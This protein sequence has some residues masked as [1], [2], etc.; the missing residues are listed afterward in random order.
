[1]PAPTRSSSLTTDP[2]HRRYRVERWLL[3]SQSTAH[4]TDALQY[5]FTLVRAAA[6]ALEAPAHSSSFPTALRHPDGAE[7][8]DWLDFLRE[9]REHAV[10]VAEVLGGHWQGELVWIEAEDVPGGAAA[11]GVEEVVVAPGVEGT[12]VDERRDSGYAEGG[13]GSADDGGR[14]GA[15]GSD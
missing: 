4:G 2:F 10:G 6:A 14:G 3:R 9:R 12:T 5:T 1:M 11:A 13:S 8:D 7:R 15:S